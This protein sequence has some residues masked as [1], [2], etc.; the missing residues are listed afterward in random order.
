MRAMSA[1]PLLLAVLL[2]TI[3]AGADPPRGRARVVLVVGHDADLGALAHAAA[4][5]ADAALTRTVVKT[6]R[7]D[8]LACWPGDASCAARLAASHRATH[9]VLLRVLW[10]RAGCVPIRDAAG[11]IVGNRQLRRPSLVIDVVRAPD[12]A[13]FHLGPVDRPF[14]D[15]PAARR[16]AADLLARL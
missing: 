2:S 9:V 10:E 13:P 5:G 3:P 12:G 11:A 8:R 4:R 1:R 15:R 7:L 14:A 6:L 16:A